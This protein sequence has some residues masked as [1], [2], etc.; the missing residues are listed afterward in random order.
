M[1]YKINEEIK[2]Y[3]NESDESYINEIISY[4]KSNY[5]NIMNFLNIKK[6]NKKVIIKF[7]DKR[8][9]FINELKKLTKEDIPFW[10]IAS[11][12]NNKNDL[13]SRIDILSL[14]EIKKIEYHKNETIENL[15]KTLLHEFIH[16]SHDIYC[17]YNT[18]KEIWIKEG[19]ATYFTNDYEN[20]KLSAN[21][22]QIQ[23]NEYVE[24]NNY[25]YLFN[26]LFKE[27]NKKEILELL[28]GNNKEE[29]LKKLMK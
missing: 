27:F 21:L 14:N 9:E 20:T 22:K 12:K 6:L 8:E 26:L 29:I 15:K 16:I 18:P 28:K 1:E 24:Y 19:L 4:F 25:R 17:N 10:V 13:T 7:W 3:Y 5:K 23:N 2:I 11:T